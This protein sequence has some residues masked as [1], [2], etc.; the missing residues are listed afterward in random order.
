MTKK[1]LLPWSS[2][3]DAAWVLHLLQ[4]DP[5]IEVAGLLTTVSASTKRVAMH[6]V[7]ESLLELQAQAAG[8]PLWK[9]PLPW[10]CPNEVYGVRMSEA[11]ARMREEGIAAVAY[12]DFFL[13]DIRAYREARHADSG[14]EALFPLWG[15]DTPTLA[16]E[17]IAGGLQ[18]RL[19]CVDTSRLEGRF[20]GRPFDLELLAA[21]PSTVDPCGE[22]GEFHT[23]VLDGP[24]FLHP[25]P[26][27]S[28]DTTLRD[29]FA[30]ADLLPTPESE[31]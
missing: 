6:G 26:V 22:N 7:R 24:M 8:L 2:G 29:G 27:Q 9:I 3:K 10:P 17:M 21:L 5:G 23:F 13:A 30:F 1:V 18:A 25:V 15:R 19:A 14:I 28:G 31:R 4:D 20:A 12:G 11:M 16:R